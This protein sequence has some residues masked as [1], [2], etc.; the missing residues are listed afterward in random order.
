MPD[1]ISRCARVVDS[2][3]SSP[4]WGSYSVASQ[5]RLSSCR[6]LGTSWNTIRSSAMASVQS[7]LVVTWGWCRIDIAAWISLVVNLMQ[8]MHT[9]CLVIQGML[10]DWGPRLLAGPG[11]TRQEGNSWKSTIGHAQSWWQVVQWSQPCSWCFQDFPQLRSTGSMLGM[12][13]LLGRG[14]DEAMLGHSA[15]DTVPSPVNWCQPEPSDGFRSGA[16]GSRNARVW[17]G[18]I[19]KVLNVSGKTWSN[20]IIALP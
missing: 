5:I 14:R 1:K 17:Q 2:Q 20:Y 4:C 10:P 12:T 11:S 19:R 18:R 15:V 3:C 16:A 7:K 13:F 6:E 9:A 8:Q